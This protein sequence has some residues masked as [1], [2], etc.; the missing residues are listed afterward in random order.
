M[1]FNI[2]HGVSNNPPDKSEATP[3]YVTGIVAGLRWFE[4][5]TEFLKTQSSTATSSDFLLAWLVLYEMEV[6]VCDRRVVTDGFVFTAM[7][8]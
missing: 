7:L 1:G 5:Q 6:A 8:I 4:K 2:H 3:A